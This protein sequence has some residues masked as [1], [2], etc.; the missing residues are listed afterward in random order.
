MSIAFLTSED[1][2]RFV[3]SVNGVTPDENGDI[4]IESGG[5]GGGLTTD[6]T[7]AL[8]ALLCSVAYIEDVSAKYATFRKVFGLDGPGSGS[9][10]GGGESGGEDSGGSNGGETVRLY[11]VVNNLTK[12]T[13]SNPQTNIS[14]GSGYSATITIENGY[15]LDNIVVT[16]GGEDITETAYQ[17]GGIWI[18]PVTGDIVITAEAVKLVALETVAYRCHNN[19]SLFTGED[20]SSELLATK[21]Y[22]DLV[23]TKSKAYK[24]TVLQ[25]VISNEG[26]SAVSPG[27]VLVGMGL[28]NGVAKSQVN[29]YHSVVA[30]SRAVA[31]EP[32]ESCRCEVSLKEGFRLIIA[33]VSGLTYT[34]YGDMGGAPEVESYE[35]ATINT[36]GTATFYSTEDTTTLLGTRNYAM[37]TH[38]VTPFV[39][40]TKVLVAGNQVGNN[41]IVRLGIMD[42]IPVSGAN[43]V[44]S[45]VKY[46]GFHGIDGIPWEF[47]YTVPA[48][49]ILVVD[50]LSITSI[51]KG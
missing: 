25:L 45:T 3:K 13:N 23:A 22:G 48:G 34:L 14:E 50:N 47:E 33:T 43:S 8:D 30:M 10:G 16:M 29:G 31:L 4:T 39:E 44:Y 9:D 49:K 37:F 32:G 11:T 18:A 46:E 51:T 24:D 42:S 26:E 21:Y 6:Q 41:I 27:D 15:A 40:E 20:N 7:N 2:K 5:S 35:I 17:D 36:G 19:L 38:T 12:V 28:A 1:E